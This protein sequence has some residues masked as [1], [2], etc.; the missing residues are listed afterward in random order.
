MSQRD[1]E[2]TA[3]EK[4]MQSSYIDYA[5]SVIIGRAL[6]DAR[7]GLKPVHRRILYAMYMLGNTHDKPT[8]KS[9][10]ITGEVIGKYHPHGD[11]AVYDTFVR[12]SQPFSMNHTLVEGQGNMGSIDGDPPAAQRYTEVRLT[13]LAEEMLEDIDKDSVPM[14]PNFDNTE[15]E[16]VVLPSKF[17]NLLVNG[18]S[19]IAVGVATNILPHNLAEVCDAIIA[20]IGNRDIQP[21]E[22]LNYI[23]G[24]DF[25]TNGIVFL[26]NDLLQAYLTGRGSVT[27]RGKVV[28]EGDK[29]KQIV[30]N[31]IPYTVNKASL[32]AKIAQLSKDKI[33][34]GI[35][36][37]RDE[38]DRNGIRIVIELRQDTSAEYVLNALYM[39]TQLQ[40]TMP[41]MNVAV[42]G[43]RLLTLNIKDFIKIFVEH[44]VEVIKR[45]TRHDLGVASD[46]LHIVEGLLKAIE[47]IDEVT[48]L[49]KSK[50]DPKEARVALM[51]RLSISE[52]QANAILDM[53]LSRLT[54]L[55]S[56][57]LE[58]EGSSLK[59]E[60]EEFNRIL[61]DDKNV[62]EIIKNETEYIKKEYGVPRK[63][64]IEAS[65][66]LGEITNEDMI[67]DEESVIILTQ[68]NYMK[69]VP[70]NVY[71]L[72]GR[73]GK[74]VITIELKEG[75]FVKSMISCMAKD[76]LLLFSNKGRAYWLKAYQ[77]PE[78]SRYGNGKAAVNLVR[79][80]EGERIEKMINIREFSG[81]YIVFVTKQGKIKRTSTEKFSRP[82]ANGVK[83]IPLDNGDELE[84]VIISD[85]KKDLLI[86]TKR[87]KAIRFNETGIRVM[88]RIAKGVRGI[89]LKSGDE[90]TN[91]LAA[92][93]G[94]SILSVTENGYGKVTPIERYRV[95]KRGGKGVLNMRINDKTGSVI[96]SIGLSGIEKIILINSKGLSIEIDVSSV[97]VTGRNASGVRL[98]RLEPGTK[99]IDVQGIISGHIS[100]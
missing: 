56:A 58:T 36:G 42:I 90:V 24:P 99:L 27:I 13:K 97:R 52:K 25:P 63:T 1:P 32:V 49:I 4:E 38:S 16:P 46:R 34:T 82:R 50:K 66:E 69:R 77:V 74:G 95:Q 35:T 3:I 30:I 70:S 100:E 48:A 23:K 98:M 15:T 76:Y 72:Q 84:T 79:L 18:S 54:G 39:H 20:Y 59:S 88:G 21:N 10:R 96:K 41:V 91:V 12:M 78:G 65:E 93:P 19:G 44:R 14:V 67:K 29:K 9:A 31:E 17:P 7:D 28:I 37:L 89:R 71:K 11:I 51:E 75:D 87:G 40:L 47:R 57:A 80:Q 5:M 81:K 53:K 55:E 68:N 8:K 43:N 2:E 86:S 83:A 92:A 33:I 60:I 26:N 85:G 61:S 6:P 94:E 62:L 64:V 73:G 22:L 45:R